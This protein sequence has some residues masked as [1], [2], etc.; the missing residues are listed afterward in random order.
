MKRGVSKGQQRYACL[1]INPKLNT[2]K[3]P[4]CSGLL[5][6]RMGRVFWAVACL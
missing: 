1:S 2:S 5:N 4:K 6:F 3:L